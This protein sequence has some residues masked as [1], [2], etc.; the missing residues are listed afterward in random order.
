MKSP[1]M[2]YFQGMQGLRKSGGYKTERDMSISGLGWWCKSLGEK[3][4]YH[5]WKHRSSNWRED[6]LEINAEY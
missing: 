6:G 2:S 5:K 1:Y 3:N 4:T